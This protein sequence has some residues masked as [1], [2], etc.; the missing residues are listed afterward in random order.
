MAENIRAI[1]LKS[2]DER[3]NEVEAAAK[4]TT[5]YR[6]QFAFAP[7]EK[8]VDEASRTVR[9]TITTG[10]VDRDNDTI[11]AGG[12]DVA[13]YL[14]NPTVLWAHD[15]SQ[16]PVG[17]ALDVTQVANGLQSTTQF[18]EKGI[19]AFA[20]TVF[21]L[22]KGGFL[23]AVSVGFKPMEYSRDEERGGINFLRQSLLEYSVVPVPANAEALV[24]ARSKGIDVEPVRRWAEM[25][26]EGIT[27][28][29]GLWV[30]KDDPI[31][32][33]PASGAATR[34]PNQP[35]TMN[36]CPACGTE[37]EGMDPRC[38]ECMKPPKAVAKVAA[39]SAGPAASDEDVLRW[40]RT[41]SKAFDVAEEPVEAS[42][43]ELVFVA[44]YVGVPMQQ[45]SSESI[46]V[47]GARM[48]SFL[49][50]MDEKISAWEVDALRHFTPSSTEVPPEYETITLN[51]K[52][53][54]SFLVGGTR[55]MR[56]RADGV[57]MVAKCQQSYCG[58]HISLY[59]KHEESAVRGEF[60]A[61]TWRRASEMNYLKGE[62][63]TLGGEFLD[64]G[65][66]DWDQLFLEPKN[67][68]AL[69]RMV[70]RINEDGEYMESR[71][72]VLMGPPGTGKTLSLRTFMRQA[73]TTF[74]WVSSRD[75]YYSGAFGAFTYAFDLAAE[76]A[77]C[78]LAFEDVDN[79]ID[80][81]V[82][83]LLKTEMDGMRRRKGILTVLTTNFPELLPDALI[84]RPGR[85]HD[86]LEMALPSEA[87]RTRML[88][89]WFPE[90]GEA[91][92]AKVAK[93]TDG[94]SGAHLF[95]LVK[96]AKTIGTEEKLESGA[97]LQ[98]ALEKLNE[99]RALVANLRDA[100]D[101]RPSRTVRRAV[102]KSLEQVAKRGRVLSAL[103]ENKIRAAS[104]SIA[105]ASEQLS[106]VLSQLQAAPEE[107]PDGTEELAIV[108][109]D[110]KGVGDD[111]V[112][113]IL[114]DEP[115]YGVAD[116]VAS[117]KSA[118]TDS[119]GSLIREETE[120]AL[121]RARGRVD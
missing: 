25:A 13:D 34:E 78:V 66:L 99:Q 41:W 20:D 120:T 38:P 84:D 1:S 45:L 71:G 29:A 39:A 5:P 23:N 118:I 93:D 42:R 61:D 103:N 119:L 81:K 48:G 8:A 51:S 110:E 47:P 43:K 53:S 64:R 59:G 98:R 105:S 95:E 109:V 97:A 7:T 76:C 111:V 62:A 80:A 117:L 49:S 55:F 16:L 6:K 67:E 63:F 56:R 4:G 121:A 89:S 69:R 70:D 11:A 54:K 15:Y 112:L 22:V 36:T 100:G 44:R 79:W 106:S 87:V 68:A 115:V 10:G 73:D 24:I 28:K 86:I 30:P 74:I 108:L 26:L 90:A 12:W 27:G 21:E 102:G 65:D 75:F 17:R 94:F 77:P 14:K 37:Y 9:W 40:N 82:V 96:F 104:E 83:D 92:R 116:V 60:V 58:L 50:A 32:V 85:F 114:P 57:K 72:A 46:Y 52:T 113:T 35:M 88:A 3:W 19:H 2:L 31:V 101:Y 18:P 91:E 33:R 107:Q